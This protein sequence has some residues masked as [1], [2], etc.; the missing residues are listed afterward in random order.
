[1]IEVSEVQVCPK[2]E[3]TWYPNEALG[4]VTDH[5]LS[6]LE[7]S[8][9][10][11]SLVSDKLVGVD[12]EQPIKC[13]ECQKQMSRYT[14]S[15]T[16]PIELDECPEHGVWLDDGE[17]GTLMQYLTEMDK[18]VSERQ[19]YALSERNLRALEELSKSPSFYSLPSNVLATIHTV[20]SRERC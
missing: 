19:D 20:H 18:R 8:D 10:S 2:C 16:C 7:A 3:G 4:N 13:P 15:L 1:M 6:E 14:Y 9:L 17:L 5:S 11:P 12:L